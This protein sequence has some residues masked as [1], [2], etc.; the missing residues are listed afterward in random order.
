MQASP[1]SP[2]TLFKTKVA[3]ADDKFSLFIPKLDTIL[4]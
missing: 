2:L 1:L 4:M 3:S